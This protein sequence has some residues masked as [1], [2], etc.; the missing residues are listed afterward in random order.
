[1]PHRVPQPGASATPTICSAHRTA[2][3][4]HAPSAP[5]APCRRRPP[6]RSARAGARAAGIAV[7]LLGTIG[8]AAADQGLALQYGRHGQVHSIGVQ[9][10]LPVWYSTGSDSW[11]LSG[12]PEIQLNR[13]DRRSEE[14]L[15]A[16]AFATF[17]VAPVRRGAYPYLEAGLG[18]NFFSR[19]RLGPKHLST[20]FQF[21]ELIGAG[22]AW[23]GR[24][25]SSGETSVGFRFLHYSNGGLKQ[26]N[27]GLEA[28]QFV[29]SHRF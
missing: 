20:R 11:R 23:G 3:A 14:L 7:L 19:D 21:G 24:F 8:G 9:W 29:V 1:M 5:S 10:M 6:G 15:Q 22:V 4:A 25:A 16:G 27:N 18:L 13:H 17:R 26:P 28:I 2:L 12:Y